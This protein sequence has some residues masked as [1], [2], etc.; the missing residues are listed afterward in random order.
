MQTRNIQLIGFLSLLLLVTGCG[1]SGKVIMPSNNQ[2]EDVRHRMTGPYSYLQQEKEDVRVV[3]SMRAATPS[4]VQWYLAVENKSDSPVQVN[5]QDMY[6]VLRKASGEEKRLQA[7]AASEVPGLAADDA[8]Q[9]AQ[10]AAEM[11]RG[12]M[13]KQ[14]QNYGTVSRDNRGSY[15]SSGSEAESNNS[16]LL[17]GRALSSGNVAS[18]FVYAPFDMAYQKLAIHVPMGGHEYVFRYDLLP[19][20]SSTQGAVR[21]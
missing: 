21:Q 6:I 8:I 16:A 12:I 13:G 2:S 1:S 14:A 17:E 11:S 7:Y 3:V 5:P 18:G 20:E 15:G 9:D 4:Y 19:P 10:M